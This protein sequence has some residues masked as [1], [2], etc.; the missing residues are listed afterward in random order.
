MNT[1]TLKNHINELLTNIEDERFLE[2]VTAMLQAYLA[3]SP[4]SAEEKAAIDEGLED[5]KAGRLVDHQQV[6]QNSQ[7]R[8]PDL[9]PKA[10]K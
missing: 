5:A 8:Y 6:K 3:A 9:Q 10:W 1:A 4:L 2:S 7:A